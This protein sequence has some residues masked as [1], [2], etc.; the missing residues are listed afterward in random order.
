[1]RQ[2]SGGWCLVA[3]VSG[4]VAGSAF[5]QEPP[6]AALP[7]SL[8]AVVVTASA[9]ASAGGLKL[10][11]AGGQV[12]R[13][14]RVGPFGGL[15]LM[16]TPFSI[17][18][19]TQKV[20]ADQQS[21][22]IADV[23]QNDPAVRVARGFGNF[24]QTY[25]IRGLPV[26][27]DDISYNGL[28]GLLPRQYLAA[29]L[30]ERVEVL[31]GASAFLNGAAPGSSGLGG[32]IN[33]A[34]KRAPGVALNE[35][36][37][38]GE[39]G[40]QGYGAFDVARRF[41]PDGAL[42]LRLNGVRREGDTAVD[43]ESRTLTAVLLGADY[44]RADL[45]VSADLG[46]QNHHLQRS[47]PSV[48]IAGGL[49]I[50]SAPD[51]SRNL[52]QPW[53][54]SNERDTFGT[55]R[56][57]YDL[58][59][60]VTLWLAGGGRQGHESAI[61]ANP[62]V[63]AA[64]GRTSAYR[65]DNT[66]RDDIVTGEA[67]VRARFATYGVTH[68]V[69]GSVVG[70]QSRS[71]NAYAFS[72]F[73]GFASNLRDPVD[74][75]APQANFFTGGVL[76]APR[77]T[78][79]VRTSSAAVADMLGFVDDRVLLTLGARYQKIEDT[80]YDYNG[81]AELSSYSEGRVTPL[82]GVVFKVDR[83]VSLYA[84]YIEGLAKGD[85]APLTYFDAAGVSH[86]VVNGGEAFRPYRSKQEEVGIKLDTGRLGATFDV[87]ST[88][89]PIPTVDASGRYAITD[90]QKNRGA[91]LSVF[92][93]VVQ[94]LRVLGGASYLHA[95]VSGREA[96]GSPRSQYNLGLDWS[97]PWVDGLAVEGRGVHTTSQYADAAN[98]QRVPGWTRFD[99]GARYLFELDRRQVAL[100]AR[101]ENLANRNQWV[102]V[103]G[104]PGSGY[105]VLGA[106]R[107][108]IASASVAF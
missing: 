56:A 7:E 19:Y 105:L 50:P 18:S 44:H 100:R 1:M 15:D 103:G 62:T 102:S 71:E 49:P 42:G 27:S 81:G 70:F 37:V 104:F 79:R 108:F 21:A 107:T 28:Y 88:R 55:V 94:G 13:G 74:V 96:I 86:P 85:V 59:S 64:D 46:Y 3:G 90:E 41:G 2:R 20:I 14:G 52:G 40:P 98:T 92:G 35:V 95:D 16:D 58:T 72:N 93:E 65:F 68:G 82:G 106:P 83:Q 48:T 101:I 29:E 57:E 61:F 84:N 26:F 22:S 67:G 31:K 99:L 9:D 10:P 54:F 25:L 91:E 87:F 76:T 17:T 75:A 33:V 80:G 60:Q 43:G 69:V 23:L 5:G 89:K 38:G 30:V 4:L 53:T 73:A 63:I 34:P 66:R 78:E 12:A 32:S 8:P 39:T 24:Q 97:L 6:G 45:R 36:T 77:L 11:Y 47:Q 51:A